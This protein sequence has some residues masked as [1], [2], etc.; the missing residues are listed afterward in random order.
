MDRRALL[1]LART[2]LIAYAGG[3]AANAVGIPAGWLSGAMIAVSV[4]AVAGLP[5][6]VPVRLADAVFIFL[7]AL[8]GS[9][10][11]PEIVNRVGAWPITLAGLVVSLILVVLAVQVYLTRVAGW[12]RTTAFFAAVPGA[13]SYVVALAAATSADLRRVVVSQS[14]RLFLLVAAI[15][16][17]IS[18]VEPPMAPVARPVLEP[19]GVFLLLVTST[20]G[21][22]ALHRLRVPAGLLSGALLVS[23]LAHATNQIDGTLPPW[24]IVVAYV[25]LG[26]M[27]GCRFVGTD[28][29]FLRRVAL[30]S[31]GA[32]FVATAVAALSALAVASFAGVPLGQVLLAFAPGGLDAMTALAIALHMDSAFIAAHQ[33]MR[34]I[35]I[36]IFAPFVARWTLRRDKT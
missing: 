25:V 30:T 22:L 6:F 35:V 24:Q 32:F 18:A 11:T 20:L 19:P 34:F 27:I 33:L 1:V 13:M 3:F 21:A 17:L 10:V 31:I 14:I 7:G 2:L 26:A 28:I 16:A 36:A 23:A 9:G 5:V 4:A 29:G 8:L 12:D 15:P